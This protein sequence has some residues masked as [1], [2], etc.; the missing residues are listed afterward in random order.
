MVL[1]G[2]AAV[3]ALVGAGVVG[4]LVAGGVPA[5]T[6]L[7][8]VNLVLLVALVAD[9]ALA[10]TPRALDLTRSGD[11]K[12]RL[13]QVA[14]VQLAVTNTG[15]RRW[16][17]HLRDAWEPTAH[18][19]V[20]GATD[21]TTIDLAPGDTL[22]VAVAVAPTRRGDR[23]TDRVTLRSLGPLGAAGRQRSTEVD[24]SV[25]TLPA[26]SSRR[27]L[28]SRLAR[29]RDMD[30]RQAIAVRAQGT[31]FDSLREYVPGDDVRSI[32]W[33]ATA[34]AADVMVRTWRPERDRRVVMVLDT[35]RTSA[36]RIGDETRLDILIDAGL[37]LAAL[38]GRAGDRVD[39]VA[40]DRRTR[41]QISGGSGPSLLPR[42]VD[43]I[44]TLEP[45]LTET[46]YRGLVSSV[47]ARVRKRALVVLFVALDR[48]AMEEGLIP[49]LPTLTARHTVIVAS[50]REPEPVAAHVGGPGP[51]GQDAAGVYLRAARARAELDRA[52]V[53]SVLARMGV[54]VVEATPSDIAPKVADAYLDMKAAGRL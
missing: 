12:V 47:L 7:L 13:G 42:L 29:L 43:G 51:V 39:L 35:G 32:D 21:R 5:W 36:V 46:D 48:P 16:R 54:R 44:A 38:A 3:L 40:H 23:P 17:G 27:H 33:R 1:T 9:A 6:A 11:R 10:P 53:A 14:H 41:L 37:L 28:P 18:A 22:R 31:E 2:R 52:H 25:R 15:T 19:T 34:R 49:A 30:G 4:L 8:W 24:W 45:E 50:V 20:D 26:F